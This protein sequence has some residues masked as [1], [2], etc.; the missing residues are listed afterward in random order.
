MLVPDGSLICNQCSARKQWLMSDK[1]KNQ[2]PD[3]RS[4]LPMKQ[5]VKT[6]GVDIALMICIQVAYGISSLV[7]PLRTRSTNALPHSFW[8]SR[9]VCLDSLK[10]SP[11]SF[12]SSHQ[13]QEKLSSRST[14]NFLSLRMI[15]TLL[16][17]EKKLTKV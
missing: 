8:S 6:V 13:I 4:I 3:K 16:N 7:D 9:R 1:M 14:E 15:S 17:A 10:P 2:T 11:Y 5:G 12:Y